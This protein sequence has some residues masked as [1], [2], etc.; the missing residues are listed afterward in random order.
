M[1]MPNSQPM[2]SENVDLNGS[3]LQRTAA[4]MECQQCVPTKRRTNSQRVAGPAVHA[5]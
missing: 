4:G 5:R 2:G 1:D 3:K